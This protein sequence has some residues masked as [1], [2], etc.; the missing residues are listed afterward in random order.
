MASRGPDEAIDYRASMPFLAIH[1]ACFLA[2]WTGVS[3]A[4]LMVCVALYAIR[5]FGITAGYHRYFSHRSYK[6]SR[7]FQFVLA[8]LGGMSRRAMNQRNGT[9]NATPISRPSSRC[10]YS[11]QKMSLNSSSPIPLFTSWYSGVS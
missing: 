6:T 1:A 5:M 4:A 3:R 2:I 11:H 7:A 10:Q 8:W 9:R